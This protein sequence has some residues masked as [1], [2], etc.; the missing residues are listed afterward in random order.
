MYIRD[1]F[2]GNVVALHTIIILKYALA[3]DA[4]QK[5]FDQKKKKKV[6]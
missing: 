4:T 2:H 5:R 1:S 3:D 6:F